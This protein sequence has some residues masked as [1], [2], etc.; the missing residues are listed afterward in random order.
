MSHALLGAHHSSVAAG[1]SA[2]LRPHAQ[3]GAAELRAPRSCQRGRCAGPRGVAPAGGLFGHTDVP[4]S[5]PVTVAEPR[6]GM[7]Q[8]AQADIAAWPETALPYQ[9]AVMMFELP[10]QAN[11]LERALV[12]PTAALQPA[13]AAGLQ[14]C[15]VLTLMAVV[16]HALGSTPGR[17]KQPLAA[18]DEQAVAFLGFECILLVCAAALPVQVGSANVLQKLAQSMLS[19]SS[20]QMPAN[21]RLAQPTRLAEF[22]APAPRVSPPSPPAAAADVLLHSASPRKRAPSQ[23]GPVSPPS[24]PTAQG[25]HNWLFNQQLLTLTVPAPQV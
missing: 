12:T 21:T 17:L 22:I 19:I 9:T 18:L 25:V 16:P 6:A 4:A 7:T 24:A 10:R 5:E 23:P 2:A 8:V 13:L 1:L 15:G 20:Y 11:K 3:R 14:R